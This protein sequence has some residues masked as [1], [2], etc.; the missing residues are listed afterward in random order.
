MISIL[1][2]VNVT[3]HND[4]F[5]DIDHSVWYFQGIIELNLLIFSWWFLLLCST[6]IL[7]CHLILD[8]CLLAGFWL[9]V[10]FHYWKLDCS[11]FVFLPDLVLG[12]YVSRNFS[13]SSTL[14]ILFAYY[15]LWF[16][17]FALFICLFVLLI[18]LFAM[19]MILLMILCFSVV[20]V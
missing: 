5:V 16:C 8:L 18:Y 3:Y 14:S 15:S 19:F 17:L 2:F 13:T 9:L 20:S 10:Q 12:L 6:V 4:W 7:A 11:Y 1:P